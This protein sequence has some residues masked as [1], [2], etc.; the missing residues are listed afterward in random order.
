MLIHLKD[1]SMIGG[2]Y[3]QNS[4]ASSSIDEESIYLEKVYKIKPDGTFGEEIQDSFGLVISKDNYKYIE[5]FY[6]DQE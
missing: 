5:F 4:Y 6:E 1:D 3:G 2:Y